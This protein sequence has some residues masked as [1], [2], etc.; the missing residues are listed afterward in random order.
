MRLRASGHIPKVKGLQSAYM[1]ALFGTFDTK[2]LASW[3]EFGSSENE[4]PNSS[5]KVKLFFKK[6]LSM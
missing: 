6:I 1:A 2:S 5:Q 3:Q 4:N